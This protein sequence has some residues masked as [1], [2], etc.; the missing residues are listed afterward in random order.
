VIRLD[1]FSPNFNEA[2]QL[3][4]TQLRPLPFYEFLYDLPRQ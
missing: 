4:F 2:G 3:G 1:R